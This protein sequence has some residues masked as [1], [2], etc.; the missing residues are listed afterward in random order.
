MNLDDGGHFLTRCRGNGFLVLLSIVSWALAWKRPDWL[1]AR[2]CRGLWTCGFDRGAF[3]SLLKRS[4]N[5]N[6]RTLTHKECF[7][8]CF[9]RFLSQNALL[10]TPDHSSSPNNKLLATGILERKKTIT[11]LVTTTLTIALILCRYHYQREQR[12][13]RIGCS[14]SLPPSLLHSLSLPPSAILH[15]SVRF[16]ITPSFPL[17]LSSFHSFLFLLFCPF[18]GAL[19]WSQLGGQW[20]RCELPSEFG[21]CPAA[22]DFSAFWGNK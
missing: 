19:P 20:K 8:H 13:L 2:K 7:I 14:S 1:Y 17:Y 11:I 5:R 6:C 4:R 15:R 16:C 9:Q 10:R 12:R 18:L 3:T 22:K 21:R